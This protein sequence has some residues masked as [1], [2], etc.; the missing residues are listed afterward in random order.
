MAGR[1]T[2]STTCAQIVLRWLSLDGSPEDV[3]RWVSLLSPD[4]L[5]RARRYR[6]SR[7]RDRFVAAR[8]QLR[9]VL[10]SLLDTAASEIA[11][12][13]GPSGKPF[14]ADGGLEF[15]LA[16]RGAVAL[17]AVTRNEHIGCDVERVRREPPVDGVAEQ[18]FTSDEVQ[19]MRPLDESARVPA[20]F[21]GWTRKEAFLKANGVGLA[22]GMGS[23]EVTLGEHE[24]AA[25]IWC[26]PRFGTAADWSIVDVTQVPDLVAA[27]VV[28]APRAEVADAARPPWWLQP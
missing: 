2:A 17:V 13:Y 7:D 20:F 18:F 26:A 1:R 21:R 5:E 14:L 9:L 15:N 12:A 6:S 24:P 23:V 22:G 11:L 8:A 25:V 3:A 16:R 28:E 27:V 4:E 10:G 19:Q